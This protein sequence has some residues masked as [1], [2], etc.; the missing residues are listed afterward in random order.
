M[1]IAAD[2]QIFLRMSHLAGSDASEVGALGIASL[3]DGTAGLAGADLAALCQR[4]K[5]LAIVE[6]VNHCPGPDFS[7]FTVDNFHFHSALFQIRQ[8][9]GDPVRLSCFMGGGVTGR[10]TIAN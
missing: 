7:A 2:K 6:S 5:M 3:T 8:Q 1:L 10:E 9:A 4:A